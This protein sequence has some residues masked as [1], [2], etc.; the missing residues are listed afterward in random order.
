MKTKLLLLLLFIFFN[1]SVFAQQSLLP[2]YE[3]KID[4][5]AKLPDT[6]WLMLEDTSGK[7]TFDQ[8]RN[9]TFNSIFHKNTAKKDLG[10]APLHTYWQKIVLKNSTGKSLELI[11][12]NVPWADRYDL[13]IIRSNGKIEHYV[14]GFYVPWSKRNGYKTFASLPF[15]LAENEQVT[16]YKRTYFYKIKSNEGLAFSFS[17]PEASYKKA[18]NVLSERYNG[19]VRNGFIS[20]ILLFGFFINMLFFRINKEKLYLY[21]ALFQLTE[22]LWYLSFTRNLMF[23]ENTEFY[24]FFGTFIFGGLCFF[25]TV[26]F[27]REFLKTP[28]YYPRWDKT[29][30]FFTI[31]WL[32]AITFNY[33]F[34]PGLSIQWKGIPGLVSSISITLLMIC[35]F[36]SFLLPKKEKDSFTSFAVAGAL[37]AFFLWGFYYGITNIYGSLSVYGVTTF[38]FIT[39]MQ[40]NTNIIEMWCVTWFTIVFTWILVQKYALLRKQLTLQAL[41]RERERTELMTQQKVELESKVE[42]RTGE[43]K[44]SI[45]ELKATQHQLIQS[46]KM[47]SLGEL[48]AGIAHEIQNP[49]NFVNNFSEVNKELL[50]EMKDEIDKGNIKEAKSLADDLIDNQEKINQHG[51]R[52]DAI[53]KG[54]LQHSRSSTDKKEPTDINA[55]A[56]EYL[57]LSYHGLRAKDKSFNATIKTDFDISLKKININPQDIGRVILNLLTN[58]FYVVNEKKKQQPEGYEPIVSVS[59]KKLNDKVEIKVKDNG[60]GIP[61]KVLD[62]IFQPFFTTKPTGQGTG[63]GLSLSYDIIK[64]HG[65]EL[66]VETKEGEGAEFIIQ[67]S[68]R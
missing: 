68:V 16:M 37:P 22:G 20:G 33:F 61:Q 47:A 4:T 5:P 15:S 29:I 36:I 59:T 56:D 27:V 63:L 8:I 46:E 41:D 21:F 18:V 25:S 9:E 13:Y 1:A 14:S 62:K 38:K 3:I 65:G 64:A 23:Q 57:R 31:L 45:E 6:H 11:T 39:W 30:L 51:K 44:K 55:L 60:N 53:V 58:A 10:Y 28:R 7:F 67:L 66:K 54:M 17:F 34:N 52:A 2:V 50:L 43:L 48:T 24:E 26:L 32:S 40:E 19:D 42:E 12:Y 49:L 35:L